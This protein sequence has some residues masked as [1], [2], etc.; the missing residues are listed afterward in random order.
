MLFRSGY[1]ASYVNRASSVL[2]IAQRE[3]DRQRFRGRA[4]LGFAGSG[5]ILEGPL[6]QGRGSWIVSARRSFLDFFTDDIGF[7]GVPVLYS[8]NAKAVL[9]VTE[10]DRIWVVNISGVDRIRL[11][12]TDTTPNDDE[13]FNFDIRYRGRR[14]ATGFN[15]QRLSSGGVG[16]LGVTHSYASVGS[17]VKDLVRNGAPPAS[18]GAD[19]VI[20]GSPVVYREQSGEQETTLKYDFTRDIGRLGTLQKIGRAH[21]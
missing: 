17:T 3:G 12:R 6:R 10:K 9:D 7:G 8:V 18:L 15:W 20:A 21:V 4:T 5:A 16:L 13:V 1:P 11:G 19:A 14:S 2:Q